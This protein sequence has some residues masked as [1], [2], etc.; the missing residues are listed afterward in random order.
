MGYSWFPCK[1]GNTTHFTSE[2]DLLPSDRATLPKSIVAKSSTW[3]DYSF[4]FL[5]RLWSRPSSNI[6]CILSFK[7]RVSVIHRMTEIC[8]QIPMICCATLDESH[9]LSIC[10]CIHPLYVI[11]RAWQEMQHLSWKDLDNFKRPPFGN[12]NLKPEFLLMWEISEQ[13]TLWLLLYDTVINQKER[14]LHKSFL[15]I[16]YQ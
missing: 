2:L 11:T 5:G 10:F 14:L 7:N 16:L 9:N 12:N 1:V 4:R 6:I 8:S 13:I 3:A 15:V